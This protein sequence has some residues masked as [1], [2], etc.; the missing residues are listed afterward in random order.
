MVLEIVYIGYV[1]LWVHFVHC[2]LEVECVLPNYNFTVCSPKQG[3]G[4]DQDNVLF[5]CKNI[6]Q[7]YYFIFVFFSFYDFSLDTGNL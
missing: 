5:C 2:K 1:E 4:D 6:M 7:I 3:R